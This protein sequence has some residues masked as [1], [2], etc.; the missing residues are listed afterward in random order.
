MV[1]CTDQGQPEDI[2][3]QIKDL[4][5]H[6]ITQSN[7]II[8]GILPARCDIEVDSALEL[9]KSYDPKGERT[10]GILTKID[11]MNVNTDI[12]SY[13]MGNILMT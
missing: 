10:I 2:K 1:A 7:T 6:Y 5:K 9:I 8:M 4:I 11:L 13:L 3:N 12:S